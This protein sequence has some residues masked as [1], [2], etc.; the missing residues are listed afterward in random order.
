MAIVGIALL[1][2]PGDNNI[3]DPSNVL[4]TVTF[5]VIAVGTSNLTFTATIGQAA[6]QALNSIGGVVGAITFDTVSATLSGI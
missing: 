3:P 4:C 5:R 1:P 6:P 2:T